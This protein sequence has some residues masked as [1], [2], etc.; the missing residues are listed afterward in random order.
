MT[1]PPATPPPSP[2]AATDEATFIAELRRLKTW[3]G[4]SFRQ[5]ERR[6]AAAGDTLP[7]ST[8]AT[9]LGKNRLPREE[10]LVT[11]TRACGL[12]EDD[13]RPWLTTRATIADGTKT[14]AT[15]TSAPVAAPATSPR[16]DTT[17]RWRPAI[18]A[19]AVLAIAFAGWV[20]LIT[21]LE[22]NTTDEQ[23]TVVVTP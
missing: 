19:A 23:N 21:G 8:A 13:M 6:A 14:N 15:Q 5:L 4:H 10:L 11:F 7:A 3:S 22:S 17:S 20:A 1:T 2:T 18:V 12:N 16:R 9:M